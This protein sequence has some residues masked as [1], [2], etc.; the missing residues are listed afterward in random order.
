[1]DKSRWP[2]AF[3]LLRIHS[4][5]S[6]RAIQNELACSTLVVIYSLAQSNVGFG[7]DGLRMK[8]VRFDC[9]VGHT[10]TPTNQDRL[11]VDFFAA[12]FLAGFFFVAFLAGFFL[13]GFLVVVFFRR[14]KVSLR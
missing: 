1:M 8:L 10:T 9:D 13:A 11:L 12:F 5:D 2:G 14:C 6:R 4:L 7:Y 3:R